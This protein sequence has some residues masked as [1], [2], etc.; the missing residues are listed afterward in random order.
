MSR[1]AEFRRS[2]Q[3]YHVSTLITGAL[4]DI[5]ASRMQD[6]RRQFE[7]NADFFNGIRSVYEI[8]KAWAAAS[9]A[10]GAESVSSSR[11]RDVYI[12]LTS[13]KRFYG[14]LNRDITRSLLKMADE[15]KDSDFVIVGR[16]GIEYLREEKVSQKIGVLEFAEDELSFEELHSI[17]T[18]AD[19]HERVF[20]VYPKMVNIFRQQVVMTDVTQTPDRLSPPEAAIEYIFEPDIPEML[21]FFERQVRHALVER[22][23]LETELARAAARMMKMRDS[24]ERAEGLEKEYGRRLRH[25]FAMLADIA[26]T[27]NFIRHSFWNA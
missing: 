15:K 22:V 7:K 25:E 16:T 2:L 13:N 27:D 20:V 14:S 4:Q 12:G 18:L 11:S 21:A 24:K 17:L 26:H 9:E 19:T 8:V 5:S 1:V 3:D 10:Q 6:L 23:M